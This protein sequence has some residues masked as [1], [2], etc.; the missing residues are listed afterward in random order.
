M[1]TI[2]LTDGPL[3]SG[4]QLLIRPMRG[5]ERDCLQFQMF[6]RK[7]FHTGSQHKFVHMHVRRIV[8]IFF[9]FMFYIFRLLR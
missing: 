6:W 8:S 1:L 5:E 7:Q 3:T 4:S 9:V 2:A